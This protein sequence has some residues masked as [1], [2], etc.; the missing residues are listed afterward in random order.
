MSEKAIREALLS[1]LTEQGIEP[2]EDWLSVRVIDMR[3]LVLI[4]HPPAK[5]KLWHVLDRLT[6]QGEGSKPTWGLWVLNESEVRALC[7][8]AGG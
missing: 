6:G 1:L 4:R 7:D 5:L 3:Y 8:E 2:P